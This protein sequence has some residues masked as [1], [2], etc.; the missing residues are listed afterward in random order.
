MPQPPKETTVTTKVECDLCHKPAPRP[1]NNPGPYGG[2]GPWAAGSYDLEAIRVSR[3]TGTA[4]PEIT[5]TVTET[6]DVC[7]A[8][9]D[10]K[11]VPFFADHK[12][13][14]TVEERCN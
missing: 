3:V 13:K 4:F 8:C 12:S 1:E 11:V 2:Q 5:T 9:W 10:D 7:P 14:P 6:F